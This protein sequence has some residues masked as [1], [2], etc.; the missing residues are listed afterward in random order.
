M[1]EA[2]ARS[3]APLHAPLH[4]I[5]TAGHVDH[6]KSSLIVRLTGIDP[7]RLREEKE[8]GMTIDLGFAANENP[9]VHVVYDRSGRRVDA[10]EFHPSWHSLLDIAAWHGLTGRPWS[11]PRPGAHAA[12]A[13]RKCG[14][15]PLGAR[16]RPGVGAQHRHD[17]PRRHRAEP[18]R[19]PGRDSAHRRGSH[20][21]RR[22]LAA[23]LR[24]RVHAGAARDLSRARPLPAR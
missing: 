17:V 19:R 4:V 11:D 18:S 24:E 14:G 5:A 7:D 3:E 16:R 1:S 8:R 6:G 13:A 9:P 23:R 22:L 15:D 20:S 2:T 21:A 12:R 10:A